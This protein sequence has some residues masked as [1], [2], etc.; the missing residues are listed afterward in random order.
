[1]RLEA[2]VV[3]SPLVGVGRIEQDRIDEASQGFGKQKTS[4]LGLTDYVAYGPALRVAV[5]IACTTK[6][7]SS[8]FPH[9]LKKISGVEPQS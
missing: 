5:L 2:V 1:M 8:V 7:T 6:G 3:Q 9:L 4:V